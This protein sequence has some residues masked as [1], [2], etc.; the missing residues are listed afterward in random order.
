MAE[1]KQDEPEDMSM[2]L[3]SLEEKTNKLE[4]IVT[5]IS[6]EVHSVLTDV[7]TVTTDLEN[8][9]NFLQGL[10]IDE[11]MLSMAENITENK[12]KDFM[13][14]KLESLTKTVVEGKLKELVDQMVRK[15]IDEQIGMMIEGKIKELKAKGELK[16][17]LDSEEL[18]KAMEEKIKQIIKIDDIKSSILIEIEKTIKMDLENQLKSELESFRQKFPE[19]FQAQ[20]SEATSHDQRQSAKKTGHQKNSNNEV[21]VIGLTACASALLQICGRR[22]AERAID[23]HYTMG[24]ISEEHRAALIRIMSLLNSREIEDKGIKLNDNA[25]IAYL[26]EK[27]SSG[28]DADFMMVLNLLNK[29]SDLPLNMSVH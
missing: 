25:V 19:M 26:F 9:L 27:I 6:K 28:T 11:V 17:P 16:L 15:F 13:E 12:L 23:D 2:K 7:R 5:E 1:S 18:Q 14:K 10:G 20:D 3:I 29:L 4:N 22:G 24:W 21:G 8:P